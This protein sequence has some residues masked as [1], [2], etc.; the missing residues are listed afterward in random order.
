MKD[1]GDS[2]NVEEEKKK[3]NKVFLEIVEKK[4]DN[5]LLIKY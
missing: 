4:A 2:V 5:N 1:S 3:K